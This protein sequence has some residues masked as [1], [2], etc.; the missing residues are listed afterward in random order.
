MNPGE[1]YVAESERMEI[2]AAAVGSHTFIVTRGA[3]MLE[4]PCLLAGLAAHE[5]AHD[6]LGHPERRA[7]TADVVGAVSGVLGIAAGAV[8]PGGGEPG[9]WGGAAGR[10]GFPAGQ[11]GGGRGEG[12]QD[13]QGGGKPEW[14]LRYTLEL[15]R[16]FDSTKKKASTPTWLST[17]PAHDERIAG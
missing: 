10:Q 14:F 9:R 6:L 17:H 7:K 4:D 13:P 2:N 8:G 3:V 11:G 1:I 12:N 15:L 16:F 5:L